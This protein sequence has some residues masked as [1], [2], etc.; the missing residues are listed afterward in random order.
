MRLHLGSLAHGQA[1]INPNGTQQVGRSFAGNDPT[2]LA[3]G[4]SGV[5]PRR[6]RLPRLRSRGCCGRGRP[7]AEARLCAHL[8]ARKLARPGWRWRPLSGTR[9]SCGA[10]SAARPAFPA[11]PLSKA[12]QTRS[13]QGRGSQLGHSE[14]AAAARTETPQR[15]PTASGSSP[16]VLVSFAWSYA[17]RATVLPQRLHELRA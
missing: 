12:E 5:A 3:T 11:G 9:P 17:R 16:L 15:A 4:R 8:E 2:G 13:L 7:G 10:C 14:L 1:E 6:A